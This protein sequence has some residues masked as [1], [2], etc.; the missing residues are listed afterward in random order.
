MS[1]KKCIP[2][3]TLEKA[4]VV[5]RKMNTKVIRRNIQLRKTAEANAVCACPD[6]KEPDLSTGPVT[7]T[8]ILLKYDGG[9]KESKLSLDRLTIIPP[10][11]MIKK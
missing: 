2:E 8:L 6:G 4:T 1:L 7:Y 5:A 10:S 3:K 9:L 11:N